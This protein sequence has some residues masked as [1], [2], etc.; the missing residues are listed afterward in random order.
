MTRLAAGISQAA[1]RCRCRAS[2]GRSSARSRRVSRCCRSR[3]RTDSRLTWT[4]IRTA[5]PSSWS[6]RR[7]RRGAGQRPEFGD[8]ERAPGRHPC[9][10]IE[11][12]RARQNADGSYRYWAGGVVG[13]VRLRVRPAGAARGPRARRAGAPRSDRLRRGVPAPHGAPRRRQPGGG[14]HRC[15]RHL[16]ARP[17]GRGRG[18]RGSRTAAAAR[19][20]YPKDGSRTSSPPTWPPPIS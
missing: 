15:L 19:Q 2:C 9:E 12:L 1:R 6:A 14:T 10:L 7:C 4:T 17:A 8:A 20:P 11:E 16:S 5:A 18:E 3:L 13:R